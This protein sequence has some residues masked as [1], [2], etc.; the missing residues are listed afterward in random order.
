MGAD[1]NRR[2]AFGGALVAATYVCWGILPVFWGLLSEVNAVYILSQR[3]I[4]SMVF[5]AGY[6]LL[7]GGF[8]EAWAVLR[9][10]NQL[11]NCLLAGSL[12]TVNWGVYIYAVTCGQ[13]LES[14]LG[15][16]IEP[17]LVGLLG[18]LVFKER[19][20][21]FERITFGFAFIGL[22]YM[23]AVNG[24]FPVLALLI[25]GSFA[26]YGAVK[27]RQHISAQA[28]LFWETLWMTPPA[29]LAM[30]WIDM[31]GLGGYAALDI[32]S[33][34]LLPASGVVTAIP[35][36]LFTAG[37]REIPYYVSGILMY[38]NPTLQFLMGWLYFHEAL[39]LHRLIAFG[40]I[41]FGIL[42]TVGERMV[43]LRRQGASG[44]NSGTSALS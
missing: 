28:A 29:L 11:F 3:I 14:S 10:K 13:V 6:L 2:G 38:I 12:C 41:W 35:L 21:F 44:D 42:F 7:T 9:D 19:P 20:S 43:M 40:F 30:F 23:V 33:F 8:R 17:V 16:F 4:W 22:I 5:M 27:K 15:Y 25:A 34:W 26:V 39:D 32:G 1:K 31:H 24:S 37:V 36:L 18:L